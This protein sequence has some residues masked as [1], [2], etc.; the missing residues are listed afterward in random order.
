MQP[1]DVIIQGTMKH[2]NMFHLI[3]A[4][5][6][7]IKLEYLSIQ[8]LLLNSSTNNAVFYGWLS[9]QLVNSKMAIVSEGIL[10]DKFL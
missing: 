2:A 10:S 4:C 6:K 9:H 5:G 8:D 3:R 7:K 1:K